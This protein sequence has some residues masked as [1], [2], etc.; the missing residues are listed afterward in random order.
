[1]VGLALGVPAKRLGI[2]G[3]LFASKPLQAHLQP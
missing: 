1:L 2:P 3:E